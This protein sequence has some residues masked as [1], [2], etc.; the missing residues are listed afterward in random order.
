M[1][2]NAAVLLVWLGCAGGAAIAA[3]PQ[4]FSGGTPLE[5]SRRMADSEMALKG[6]SL[7]WKPEGKAKWDYSAGLFM[8]SLLKL[9][10]V[11]PDPRYRHFT[12]QALGSFIADDGTIRTY[13]RDE[14]QL[15]AIN[16]GR[17]LLALQ[18]IAPQRRYALAVDT[19]LAQFRTQ[20]RTPEGGFWHK[21]RYTNQMWLDGIY[22]AEPF[23][24]ECLKRDPAPSD[25]QGHWPGGYDD[26]AR[27]FRLI[28]EHTYDA[29]TGLNYHGWDSAHLQ[30]WANPVTGCSSNF[31]GRA[32]GWYAMALVDVLDAF[33]T[34]HPA[35]GQLVA[36]LQKTARGIVKWQDA[37]TGLWWQVLD[38]GGRPGNYLEATASAM[39]VYA[40][41]KGVNQGYL[42]RDYEPAIKRGYAGIIKNFITPQGDGRWAL[43]HCC[44]V[45]GLGG[46]PSDGKMRDGSFNYY[47]GEPVVTNDLKGVGPF[48]LDGI[49]MEA[50][51][52]PHRQ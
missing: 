15:D 3:L 43:T 24:A 30:S 39:F 9:N 19:L 2:L 16:P 31:W 44:S 33:P 52:N 47:V 14:Y 50:L 34:N 46:S 45:A 51:L 40:L 8:L 36:A 37:Q 12:D 48:I 10:E 38:Q 28:D 13:K 21:Q 22:M 5:W 29:A 4:D 18:K 32:E 7:V 27:Q 17:T 42:P 49:E 20:P 11:A 6:D 35:R 1:R 25:G 26:I 41:A 23:Y